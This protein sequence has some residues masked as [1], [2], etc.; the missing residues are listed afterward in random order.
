MRVSVV[1]GNED[2]E[3]VQVDAEHDT[4]AFSGDVLDSLLRQACSSA[5]VTAQV[6]AAWSSE[7]VA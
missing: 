2:G 3:Y 7:G 1:I 6:R 4:E 5:Q